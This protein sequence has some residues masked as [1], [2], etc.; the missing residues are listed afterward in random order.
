MEEMLDIYNEDLKKIGVRSREDVHKYGFKHKVVQCYIINEK[1]K[2]KYVYFQQRSFSKNNYPG[3]YDIACA[4]H[5]DSGEEPVNS[6]MRELE[7]EVGLKVDKPQLIFAGIKLE[8]KNHDDILDDEICEL[9]V[10]KI[11]HE[12]FKPGEEVEDMVKV[13]YEDYKSWVNG[14]T[15]TLHVFSLKHNK[16]IELN[17]H[18]ICEHIREYNEELIYT[19]DRL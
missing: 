15:E 10:L 17:E 2:E 12:N 1:G 14:K 18:N 16:V 7:E 5:I 11:S 13:L 3:F 9:Y 6:M 19:M 4:G 8:N